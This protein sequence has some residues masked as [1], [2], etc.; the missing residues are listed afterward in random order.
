MVVVTWK[1]VDG[2]HH[3]ITCIEIGVSVTQQNP[4]FSQFLISRET[5]KPYTSFRPLFRVMA[6]A[7]STTIGH[8]K[9]KKIWSQ[10]C[11]RGQTAAWGTGARRVRNE[12]MS[13]LD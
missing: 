2:A 8:F 6:A 12:L 7:H 4:S 5:E 1:K 10:D 3:C 9:A 13:R 11:G